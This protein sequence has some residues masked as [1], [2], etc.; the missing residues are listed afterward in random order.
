MY[1]RDNERQQYEDWHRYGRDRGWFD[2]ASDEVRSWF[3][4]EDAERRRRM[5]QMER[6]GR[7]SGGMWGRNEWGRDDRDRDRDRDSMAPDWHRREYAGSSPRGGEFEERGRFGMEM[8][9]GRRDREDYGYR[10]GEFGGGR[11]DREGDIYR[12]GNQGMYGSQGMY[13]NQNM[14]G[15]QGMNQGFGGGRDDYSRSNYGERFYGRAG[16]DYGR[17]RDFESGMGWG[18]ER[19]YEQEQGWR[20]APARGMFGGNTERGGFFGSGERSG[21]FDRGERE[22]GSMFGGFH[23]GRGPRN[24]Q[25]SDERI[26]DE[27]HQ[28]LTFH[29]EI[30]ATDI[31]IVVEQ[32]VVTLKG[33]VDNRQTKRMAEDIVEDV[34]GVREVRNELR[35]NQ[36]LFGSTPR[37]TEDNSEKGRNNLLSR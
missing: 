13:R 11:Y 3:G 18:R 31:E 15:S 27:I 30:D 17:D 21:M 22:R 35:S 7:S 33:N 37:R 26:S 10:G 28:I 1:N 24:Y 8:G 14:Y 5:D 16:R 4:D 9:S 34:Y 36:G 25:R 19:D 23:R 29:P 20:N 6:G 2:R 32:G 12:G